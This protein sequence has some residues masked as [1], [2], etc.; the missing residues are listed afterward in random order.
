M[1]IRV[2]IAGGVALL[3]CSW[4][5]AAVDGV[6]MNATTGKP[7]P[8]V[9]VNLIQPTAKGMQTLG[10]VK[11]DAEGKFK[12]DKEW[13]PGPAMVQAIYQGA[14]YTLLMTPG[15]PTSGVQLKIYDSTNKPGT[16]K[17]A[18]DMVLFEPSADRLQISETF[19]IQ[20]PTKLTFEDT[21]KGS[22]QFYVPDDA[23]DKVKVSITPPG[24]MPLSR[25]AQK[26]GQAG[27]YKVNYPLSPGDT[28]ID[29]DYSL[30]A[31]DSGDYTFEG[32]SIHPDSPARLVSPSTVT[33]S[34]EGIQDLGQEP[35]TQAHVYSIAGP[36]YKVK[37]EGIGSLRNPQEN[38]Q[39]EDLGQPRVDEEPA[40][41]YS[42][43]PWVLGLTFGILLLG[44]ALLY[45][46]GA[47]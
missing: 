38:G 15:T 18:E 11:S 41:V 34:G 9:L 40:R 37:I 32:K 27:V 24:G 19:L 22:M 30:P 13:P 5:Q 17:I 6:V 42:Q 33:L 16:A 29:V 3:S 2:W 20:N 7:E 10:S 31:A 23:A 46:K 4:L 26:T 28:R 44:G 25:P 45:R 36:D 47:A 21:A 43:L 8:S 14:T 12:I 39:E 1:K 35:Q